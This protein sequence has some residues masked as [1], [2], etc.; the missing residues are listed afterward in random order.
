MLRHP[1]C[2][3]R[4]LTPSLPSSLRPANRSF[5]T[6]PARHAIGPE[7]P[8]FIEVPQSR[9]PYGRAPR[10]IKG[11]LP[12]PRRVFPNGTTHA[13]VLERIQNTNPAST[14][15]QPL[16]SNTTPVGV[17]DRMAWK[18]RV[19]E[20]RRQNLAEGLTALYQRKVSMEWAHACK[21]RKKDAARR[22]LL[23][24]PP[25]ADEQHTATTCLA[26]RGLPKGILPDPHREQRVAKAKRQ[27]AAMQAEREDDRMYALHNLYMNARGF[28]TTEEQLAE[29]M[30][31]EFVDGASIWAKDGAPQTVAEKIAVLG[32][33]D[34]LLSLFLQQSELVNHRMTKIAEKITGGKLDA[35]TPTRH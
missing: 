16:A 26:A 14:K 28:I 20:Q 23:L 35:I 32:G 30:E 4:T 9:Q 5:A 29:L 21:E 19:T 22:A 8:K 33:T 27:V 6:S 2:C 25:S 31:R 10:D 3:L 17:N 24:A 12:P 11:V 13:A 18:R 7:S 34:G 1:I 15:S